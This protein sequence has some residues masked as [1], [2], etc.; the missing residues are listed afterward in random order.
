[1][2]RL[3][4]IFIC[5]LYCV[6]KRLP[7]SFDS[8]QIG[9]RRLRAF[10]GKYLLEKCGE[11]VNIEK[12]AQFAYTV[13]LGDRSGLGINCRLAGKVIIGNDVMMG[14]NVSC[15]PRNHA[16][17][18]VDI[19]MDRQ[20]FSAESPIVIGNNVWIG[21][22]SILLAG[23]TVGD[24]A[25]IG[26]GAVVTKEVPPYAIVGGNPARVIRYRKKESV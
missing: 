22:N 10:C 9:Q 7:E 13:E 14:P 6:A 23:V 25:I 1:M 5:G 11:D 16:F 17:D 26:A 8:I 12:G 19:P 2:K 3:V 21:A 15:Y 18:R 24:G 20:G 4:N